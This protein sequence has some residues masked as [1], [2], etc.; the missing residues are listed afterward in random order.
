M[1]QSHRGTRLAQRLRRCCNAPARHV[2]RHNSWQR[3]GQVSPSSQGDHR[4][5]SGAGHRHSSRRNHG[6]VRPPLRYQR[7][8]N[9][10]LRDHS[11]EGG[12]LEEVANHVLVA[13]TRP[14]VNER[15]LNDPE[16]PRQPLTHPFTVPQL[17]F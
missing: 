1:L 4:S 10:R 9:L 8:A 13:L 7:T 17:L 15:S 5:A 3:C 2:K 12:A 14:L 11:A 6:A 16:K